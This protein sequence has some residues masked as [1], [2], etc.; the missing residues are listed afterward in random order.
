MLE[1][2]EFQMH[3]KYHRKKEIIIFP[4]TPS[5]LQQPDNIY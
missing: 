1:A 2:D 5:D 4:F 3:M